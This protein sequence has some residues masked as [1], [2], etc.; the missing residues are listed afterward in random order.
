MS[1]KTPEKA[2]ALL[3]R[4]T[5]E[6]VN[7]EMDRGLAGEVGTFIRAQAAEIARLKAKVEAGDMLDT[8]EI[9]EGYFE[10]DAPDFNRG[11]DAAI[12]NVRAALSAYKGEKG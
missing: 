2:Q 5:F 4:M 11:Y 9:P 7:G 6:V 3:D 1:D 8:D 10:D 12:R